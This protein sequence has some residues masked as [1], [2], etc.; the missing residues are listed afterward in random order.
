[1]TTA[2]ALTTTQQLRQ[3]FSQFGIPETVVSDNGPQF[4]SAYFQAFCKTN[5]IHHIRV[6]PYHPS[7]NG[8]AERAVKIVK[9][10][11]KKQTQGSLNDKL[12]R[13]LLQYR[14]TPHTTTGMIPAELVMGRTLRSRLNF[15]IP[16][17][18]HH[19]HRKQDRQQFDHDKRSKS[20]N[21]F[22]GERVFVK[23]HNRSGDKW[24]SGVIVKL[25]GP[26]SFRVKLACG[27]EIRAHQDHL[28]SRSTSDDA[29][30][31][32]AS[33]NVSDDTR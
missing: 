19:I 32:T 16:N 23:N 5:G 7:S 26:V 21:F 3:L 28:R 29:T 33:D 8:L 17:V 1:M 15:L 2:T 18:E 4:S 13:V 24:L 27:R 25:T 6:T 9:L 10:G 14:Y 11:L 22:E 30:P 20:R 31:L 12:A